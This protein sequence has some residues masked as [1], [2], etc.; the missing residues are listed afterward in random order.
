MR[1][2]H[3]LLSL[4]L[5]LP[6][7]S[8]QD[9][10]SFTKRLKELDDK[11]LTKKAVDPQD[12]KRE[13]WANLRK[14]YNHQ[15]ALA[16]NDAPVDYRGAPSPPMPGTGGGPPMPPMPPSQNYQANSANFQGYKPSF[17]QLDSDEPLSP[18]EFS[19][20]LKNM[21]QQVDKRR[22]ESINRLS[23]VEGTV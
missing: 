21:Y 2:S 7:W 9:L 11:Y 20:W 23:T 8:L 12:A 19:S 1:S 4:G 15:P 17:L 18:A 3:L 16:F 13:E 10:E 14:K 6:I 22:D 5:V